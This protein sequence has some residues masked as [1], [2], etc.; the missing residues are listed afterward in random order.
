MTISTMHSSHATR[1]SNGH[2]AKTAFILFRRWRPATLFLSF[3]SISLV[4]TLIQFAS[5]H[6]IAHK[7]TR[8]H[9]QQQPAVFPGHPNQKKADSTAPQ[10]SSSKSFPQH[11][12]VFSTSCVPQQH[13][14]SMV[15]FYHAYK[16]QQPGTVTRITS[17][18]NDKEEKEQQEFFNQYI[19][20]MRPQDFFIHF[21][22]D[23]SRVQKSDGAPYKYM[24]KPYG[25]RHWMEGYLNMTNKAAENDIIILMDPDMILLRPLTFDFSDVD[26]HLWVETDP[27]TRVVRHGFPMSQ[28]DGYLSN[29]W[30]RLNITHVTRNSSSVKPNGP[31]GPK[32]YN[33]GP[34]YLATAR[35]MYSIAVK[36]TE[37]APRVVEIH[38]HLFSEMYGFIFATV[39]LNLPF[40]MLKDIVVSTTTSSNREGWE[41]V[42]ALETKEVCNRPQNGTKLPIVLH[43]CER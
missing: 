36:W 22:P 39:Q 15:F 21:T 30:M 2:G 37:F 34:P 1:S 42:D 23:F 18:C 33:T 5:Q 7:H 4:F 9:L 27:K 6:S 38:P 26:N 35:D 3:L 14:E 19:Q 41:F 40:T 20:P 25:L 17:G 31:D 29:D 11:H 32:H 43:Y 28:Q 12:V 13:W 16:V 10:L 8:K 24:N